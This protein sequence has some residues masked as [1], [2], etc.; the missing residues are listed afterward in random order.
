MS[1][2][3][4][5]IFIDESG[6]SQADRFWGLGA[7]RTTR[8][9]QLHQTVARVRETTGFRG[10]RFHFTEVK[11]DT[12][13]I[14]RELASAVQSLPDVS[15]RGIYVDKEI[16]D[17]ASH[18]ENKEW[19]V[20]ANLSAILLRKLIQRKESVAVMFDRMPPPPHGTFEQVVLGRLRGCLL[21]TSPS[22]RDRQKSRMPSSA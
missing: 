11:R 1:F 21:Y 3:T 18:W 20:K 4:A 2:R 12:R 17:P 8:P 22:P 14:Y 19:R 6:S 10:D 7:I 9:D 15:F 16:A 5:T 13:Y